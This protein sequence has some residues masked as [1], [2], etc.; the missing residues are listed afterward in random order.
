MAYVTDCP[1]HDNCALIV[2]GDYPTEAGSWVS[3]FE[4]D[5]PPEARLNPDDPEQ[6]TIEDR[7][8]ST[9]TD[10]LDRRAP[11]AAERERLEGKRPP[12]LSKS[13]QGS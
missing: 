13:E 7:R 3:H 10:V 11:N 2:K 4:N 12:T 5:V 9:A 1:D 6:A 8:S